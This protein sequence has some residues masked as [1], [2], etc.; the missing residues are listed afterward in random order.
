M[1]TLAYNK[2]AKF[3]YQLLETFEA[4]LKLIGNEVKSIKNG[5]ASL[6]GAYVT[7]YKNELY[8]INTHVPHYQNHADTSY[9]PDRSRK[10]LM[11]RKEI[12]SLIGKK[13]AS[14]LTIVPIRLYLKKGR[15]KLELSLAKGKKEFDK[16]HSIRDREETRDMQRKLK[17]F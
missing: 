2:R 8:L 14:G 13:S 7:V 3:D 9:D 17:N 12:D 1:K 11:N 4:G 5:R 16:R 6:K 10:L 15:I